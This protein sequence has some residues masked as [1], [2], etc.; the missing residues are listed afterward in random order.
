MKRFL[1]SSFCVLFFSAQQSRISSDFEIQ[2]MERQLAT[3]KDFISKLSAHLNLGDL[4]AFRT[5]TARANAEYASAIDLATRERLDARRA[6]DMTRYA[7]AT[8]YAALAEAKLGHDARAF[9]LSEEALRYTSDSAKTW[10]LYASTMVQLRKTKKAASAAR[11]AVA[12]AEAD[13]QTSPSLANQ[14][15]LDV[16]RY[17]LA[18]FTDDE[19]LLRSVIASLKSAAFD[20]L[21]SAVVRNESF[22][23]YSS[24]RGDVA[25]YVS[26]L[27]RTQLRLAGLVERRGDVAEAR[28]MYET[29]L[30]S[31]SDDPTALAAI[32]RLGPDEKTYAAAF[33]ANPFSIALVR[34]YQRYLERTKVAAPDASTTGAEVRRALQQIHAGELRSA[35]AALDAL[36][37]RFPDNDTLRTLRREAEEPA[38]GAPVF[39]TSGKATAQPSGPEL[40]KLLGLKLTPEQRATLD[41]MTFSGVVIFTDVPFTTGTIEGVPFRFAQPTIFNGNFAA[42]SPL[43]LVYRILGVTDVGGADGLLL[44]PIR[45]E[46]IQ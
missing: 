36:L 46:P 44:E 13:V 22:E 16:Y 12:I 5:E 35:R 28:K 9:A 27:N 34:E 37:T 14:L 42:S 43:R 8:S 33:D 18:T 30:A 3:S 10:N 24:A 17:S 21:K 4:R 38:S 15:D 41:Q 39:L 1:L 26:L 7:T 19:Q 32:A 25:T 29:V 11:N 31:R 23:I 20:P 2:Q 40:R 45:L 6:S